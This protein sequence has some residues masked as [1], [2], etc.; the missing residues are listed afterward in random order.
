MI[1]FTAEDKEKPTNYLNEV[2]D[3]IDKFKEMN[4]LSLLLNNIV[5]DFKTP[6]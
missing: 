4:K 5:D 6:P 3:T 2:G 1:I